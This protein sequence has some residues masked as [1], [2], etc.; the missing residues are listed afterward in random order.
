MG[1][2]KLP[3]LQQ[4][5]DE[6]TSS[7]TW[8]CPPDVK[9]AE[10]LVVGAGGGGGGADNSLNTRTAQGGG[11]GGGAVIKQTLATTPG[12]SY[13]ITVGAGGTG[14]NATAGTNGGISEIVLSGT[15][16]IKAFGGGGG[17]GVDA[18][19]VVLSAAYGSYG[20]GGG[21]AQSSTD[22]SSLSGGGGGANV[23]WTSPASG[24]L[25]VSTS[26]TQGLQGTNGC[27]NST[28]TISLNL[29]GIPGIDNFG[30]GGNG[31]VADNGGTPSTNQNTNV[32]NFGAGATVYLT[33]A[34]AA[35]GNSATYYGC[36]GGGA[37]SML[38]TDAATG[39]NG[40]A[41]L[42]RITYLA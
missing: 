36:G 38:S 41:G 4:R 2:S 33:A 37:I 24:R 28:G 26:I 15:T 25:I 12:N 23:N 1:V 8:V 18:T 14:G 17:Q 11:G 31:A 9:S 22:S 34:G 42:V 16:L 20:G 32:N 13:T 30:S 7:G 35:N 40:Y 10:F 29:V 6:F 5:T 39:G 21:Q 3:L 19:D 27:Q